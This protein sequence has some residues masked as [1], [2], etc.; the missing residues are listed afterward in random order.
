MKWG[1]FGRLGEKGV[2]RGGVVVV[3]VM[4]AALTNDIDMKANV[5]EGG[6]MTRKVEVE[7]G[8]FFFFCST[9]KTCCFTIRPLRLPV[10]IEPESE[11]YQQDHI[12]SLRA[13]VLV[14]V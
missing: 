2:K 8:H 13:S 4:R 7:L 14:A 5:L 6:G 11:T 12:S 9:N 3:V 10:R 1:V